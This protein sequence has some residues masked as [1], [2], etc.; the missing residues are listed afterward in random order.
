MYRTQQLDLGHPTDGLTGMALEHSHCNRQ[1]G[2]I[3]S[4]RGVIVVV[5]RQNGKGR[6]W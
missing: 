3:N 5:A 6:P 2:A 1:A 4:N